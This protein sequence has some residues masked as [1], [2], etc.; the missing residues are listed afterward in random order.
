MKWLRVLLHLYVLLC[1]ATGVFAQDADG[2]LERQIEV[3]KN[4][5]EKQLVGT[6][7][8][9]SVLPESW[10]Q[11][12]LDRDLARQQMEVERTKLQASQ[13][14]AASMERHERLLELKLRW[15]YF[16]ADERQSLLNEART[17][18]LV[19][20]N[21]SEA[22]QNLAR[23]HRE[24][25]ESVAQQKS[26]DKALADT[27][28]EREKRLLSILLEM[29]KNLEWIAQQRAVVAKA[30][31]SLSDA[32]QQWLQTK[33]A[34]ENALEDENFLPGTQNFSA[35][36]TSL[37]ERLQT[38]NDWVRSQESFIRAIFGSEYQVEWP[39]ALLSVQLRDG[40]SEALRALV[41]AIQQKRVVLHTEQDQVQRQRA[42]LITQWIDWQRQYRQQLITLRSELI[43]EVI[44]S[45]TYAL[46]STLP[47]KLELSTLSAG[48]AFY[49]WRED[50]KRSNQY[51]SRKAFTFNMLNDF[52]KGL[53][54]TAFL[55]WLLYRRK[56]VLN[57]LQTWLRAPSLPLKWRRVTMAVY[58]LCHYLYVF[59][60]VIILGHLLI[61]LMV[62]SGFQAANLLSPLLNHVL[63]F[64][65]LFGF[66]NFLSPLL[67]QRSY[68][69]K[70]ALEEVQ[71]MEKIFEFFPKVYLYYWLISGSVSL[72]LLQVLQRNLLD[73]Y[74]ANVLVLLFFSGLFIAV[75]WDRKNWR[76]I[77]NIASQ[78]ALWKRITEK[79]QGKFWEPAVLVVGGGLGVYR[80]AWRVL[81]ERF[82][83]H[84]LTRRFQ[85]MVSRA[86]L[87]R[88]YRRSAARVNP[89][90]FPE[91]Y[92]RAFH[93]QTPAVDDWYVS[94]EESEQI[95]ENFYRAWQEE[96]EFARILLCGDRGIGKSEII[97]KFARSRD[98]PVLHTQLL[99]G[100]QD[101]AEVCA[102]FGLD[103]FND[104]NL[105]AAELIEKL[106]ALPPQILCI[107]NLENCMLRRVGGFDT[108]AFV[109]DFI[110]EASTRHFCLAT[111]TSH[112]WSI[113]RRALVGI[114]NFSETP[115]VKGMT[116]KQL[117]AMLLNRHRSSTEHS[118]DFSHLNLTEN[119]TYFD[120]HLAD[121]ESNNKGEELYFRILW[122]Y[123]RGNPRQALY[124]WKASLNWKGDH[125]SVRLFEV[126]EQK[127][128]E[129]LP[130]NTL[131][132]LAALIEHNGLDEQSLAQV[133]N[134]STTNIRRRIEELRPYGIVYLQSVDQGKNA[135]HIE[136]FWTRAVEGYLE[137]RQFLF[138]GESQ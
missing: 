125:S 33:T 94:R 65:L 9:K 23:A 55:V 25:E 37:A 86:L 105:N 41:D 28:D 46:N 75:W 19:Q 8:L 99:A 72:L 39:Y 63:I 100:D 111:C 10:L 92:W 47:L 112:A 36:R 15:L 106:T 54:V 134:V 136:S 58:D 89:G 90:W 51:R 102:R 77:N 3:L 123:T 74:F 76:L 82:I 71:A 6:D 40:D 98:V 61:S 52:V 7:A 57:R 109:N 31:S 62:Q 17:R 53:L 121:K 84:E 87:E 79:A 42:E 78:S 81:S 35:Y 16:K 132:L 2:D 120:R 66:V 22:S 32:A 122:D 126:P 45:S 110:L 38:S 59:V 130:D 118:P 114:D 26:V 1:L 96:E 27:H 69:Q 83:E 95:L 133:M 60:I 21:Q 70:R 113:T 119:K 131:M 97:A 107:E 104:A 30:Q 85:A 88:Q 68:R 24:V 44:N 43:S 116:E 138:R 49:L 4:F 124:Y 20:E 34:I 48:S 115:F 128:L 127:V 129:N 93:F 137:K 50:F 12:G 101:V 18:Q 91:K 11:E 103:L 14:D 56:N 80:V 13:L 29:E 117:K 108:F 135:W 67:S 73:F 64:F 5:Y